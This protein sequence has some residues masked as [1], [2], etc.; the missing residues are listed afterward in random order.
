MF[1]HFPTTGNEGTRNSH[2][3]FSVFRDV[4]EGF[5]Q[6]NPGLVPA[7]PVNAIAEVVELV[8]TLS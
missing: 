8:D 4:L 1:S 5:S 3:P 7:R 6:D 2:I